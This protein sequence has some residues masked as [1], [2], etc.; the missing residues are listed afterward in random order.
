MLR[1]NQE[2]TDSGV[3]LCCVFAARQGY[4]Y[5]RV[6]SPNS[7]I[8][9][10]LLYH[11]S[12]TEIAILFDTGHG[13]NKRLIDITR[14]SQHYSQ[15]MY[16]AMLGL[17]ALT[18]CDTVSCFKGVGKIKPLQLLLKARAYCDTLKQ[19]GGG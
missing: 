15:P 12:K 16:E 17:H 1:S 11:A 8:F 18:G 13:N 19:L 9:W 10:I 14:L 7:D 6:R 3:V 4:E 2:E 5:A